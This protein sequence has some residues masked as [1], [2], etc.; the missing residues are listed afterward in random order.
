MLEAVPWG[1]WATHGWVEIIHCPNC[2]QIPHRRVNSNKCQWDLL[3]QKFSA[4]IA[5]SRAKSWHH[6]AVKLLPEFPAES[7]MKEGLLMHRTALQSCTIYHVLLET[8]LPCAATSRRQCDGTPQHCSIS[9]AQNLLQFTSRLQLFSQ[10]LL[11]LPSRLALI[12]A[13]S[14]QSWDVQNRNHRVNY[15][16]FCPALPPFP[17]VSPF[18]KHGIPQGALPKYRSRWWHWRGCPRTNTKHAS[19]RSIERIKLSRK[20]KNYQAA[21]LS[22]RGRSPWVPSIMRTALPFP[23]PFL[24]FFYFF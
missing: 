6:K 18:S 24:T 1:T 10:Q 23:I 3:H 20:L 21:R 12:Y 17:A 14:R 11:P 7:K 8:L 16:N 22:F 13:V 5:V 15:P 2:T 19:H 9:A 4:I